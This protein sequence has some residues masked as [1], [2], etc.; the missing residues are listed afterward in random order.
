MNMIPYAHTAAWLSSPHKTALY[1]HSPALSS[2]HSLSLSSL[3][4]SSEDMRIREPNR[5]D[6]GFRSHKPWQSEIGFSKNGCGFS[7]LL[8]LPI[9]TQIALGTKE[10]RH[11]S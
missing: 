2:L 6:T 3:P 5:R 9:S 1:I 4:Q 7:T 10:L 11:E 8:P